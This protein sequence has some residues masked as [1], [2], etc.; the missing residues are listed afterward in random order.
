MEGLKL[1]SIR[2]SKVSLANAEK[3]S[4]ESAYYQRSFI[5]RAAIWLGLKFMKP[6]VL[7][8]LLHMMYEE[9]FN[10]KCF[11]LEDVIRTAGK[12]DK[13]ESAGGL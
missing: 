8:K 5:L 2:V 12:L 6:G 4:R 13:Q 1:I 7:H 9:E 11:T 10:G 3:L